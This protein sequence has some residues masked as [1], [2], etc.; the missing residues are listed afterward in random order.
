[1][2]FHV[3][4]STLPNKGAVLYSP[5]KSVGIGTFSIVA[6]TSIYVTCV[7]YMIVSHIDDI[8]ILFST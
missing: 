1:M 4:L 5:L 7:Y 3:F 2:L 6:C 8:L